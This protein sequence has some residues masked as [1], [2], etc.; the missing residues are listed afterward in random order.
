MG[1]DKAGVR[2]LQLR[3]MREANLKRGQAKPSLSALRADVAEASTKR[4]KPRKAKKAR[5]AK[6]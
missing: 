3:A 6:R 5:K 2:E 1:H 4:G